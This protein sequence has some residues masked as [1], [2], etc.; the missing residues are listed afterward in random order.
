[1]AKAVL[2]V[3]DEHNFLALLIRILGKKGFEVTTA[4]GGPE[5]LKALET[6]P[7]DLALLDIRMSPMSGL[8]ILDELKSR[9]PAV[10][11]IMM[12]AYPT[13]ETRKQ[14]REKGASAYLTK[15]IDL[16]D[17]IKTIDALLAH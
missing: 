6:R 9:Q 16:D 13:E 17:M 2:A 8:Q 12:T 7:Y 11:V 5:A 15:P 3:D 4:P 14:A 1:M 10:K